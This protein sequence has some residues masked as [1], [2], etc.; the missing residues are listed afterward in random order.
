M[1]RG[2]RWFSGQSTLWVATGSGAGTLNV[3][4][5][6]M[7]TILNRNF[8][9]NQ[10]KYLCSD[11]R[12]G[13]A[14]PAREHGG[15]GHRC[16]SERRRS[17]KPA[18]SW[19]F[20]R[21]GPP[22][23]HRRAPL[24]QQPSKTPSPEIPPLQ[25]THPQRRRCTLP[26]PRHLGENAR[27]SRCH[28]RLLPTRPPTPPKSCPS[29]PPPGRPCP[30]PLV[31]CQEAHPWAHHPSVGTHLL[32]SVVISLWLSAGPLLATSPSVGALTPRL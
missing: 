8:A 21:S 18:R 7:K 10:R 30:A 9:L 20:P 27:P 19:W 31:R 2:R 1:M 3:F 22:W 5:P 12:T 14:P 23:S 13:L 29:P 4:R 32:K 6:T 17:L 16:C 28:R 25:G 24:R 11:H 15:T 26:C